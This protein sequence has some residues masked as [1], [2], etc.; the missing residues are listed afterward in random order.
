M[1][2]HPMPFVPQFNANVSPFAMHPPFTAP[3]WNNWQAQAPNDPSK[4]F[5]DSKI[6]PKLIAAAGEWTEHRVRLKD[7]G[8]IGI[9][10]FIF[11]GSRW[12]SILLQCFSS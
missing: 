1:P 11:S 5:N 12:S 3:S 9:T 6:D 7:C 8:E 2:G 4:M 10:L